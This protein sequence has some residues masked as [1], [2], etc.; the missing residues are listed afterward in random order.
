MAAPEPPNNKKQ[1]LIYD[2]TT[3]KRTT[4]NRQRL[5]NPWLDSPVLDHLKLFGDF[6]SFEKK[7]IF[8]LKY[9]LK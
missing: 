2:F 7:M 8:H 6:I 4:W 3:K 1:G 5:Q 9:A